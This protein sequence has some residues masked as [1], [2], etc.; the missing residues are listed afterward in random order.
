M[1]I[2]REKLVCGEVTIQRSRFDVNDAL[3][4]MAFIEIAMHDK[5]KGP[6]PETRRTRSLATVT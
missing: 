6:Q 3:T 1:K 4:S 5:S 2:C